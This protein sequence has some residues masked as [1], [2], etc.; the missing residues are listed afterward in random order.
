MFK[1][2]VKIF[3]VIILLNLLL[4]SASFAYANKINT[5]IEYEIKFKNS[6]S[7]ALL[8]L[9]GKNIKHRFNF[10]NS[11]FNNIYTFT[12]DYN[13]GY[14]Q[15]VLNST[16]VYLSPINSVKLEAISAN[17]PGF[18]SNY[19]D[20]DKTWGLAKAGFLEA[21]DKTTGLNSNIVAVIDTGIDE[22]HEDLQTIN[23]VPGFDFLK[24]QNILVGANSDDN[25]HGT[26]VAG[27]L[28]ATANNG[29]GV[30]GTNWHVSIMP[31]KALDTTGKGD[32]VSIA[33]A[34]VWATD[35]GAQFIN[36]SVGGIGFGHDN[37]LAD[38]VTYAFAR[39]VLIVAAAGND[40]AVTGGNIDE[41]PVFPI[42]DDNNLN[43]IIGVTA[44][45]QNDLKPQF[46]NY[47]KNCIDVT[48]PGK[49]ILST[50]SFDPGTKKSSPNSY[51]YAS[52]TSLAVPFVVGQAALIKS[53]YPVA[54]NIQIRDRI[55]NTTD[56]VD[57]LNLS[58]CG[59]YSCKG[60]LGTGRINILRSLES[61]I[62]PEFSE[63]DIVRV[64][65]A[66]GIMY[67]IIGGQKRLIS[68]TVYNLRFSTSLVKTGNLN[69]LSTYPEG[70]YITPVDGTLVKFDTSPTVYIIQNGQK[71]P[72]TYQ[73]FNQRQFNFS[74]VYT[75]S[76]AELN[77][78]S[79]ASFL[80][81]TEGTLLKTQKNKTVY[82]VVG[83]TIHPI[84]YNFY[85]D[86]GL[87]IFPV[88]IFPDKDI[89]SFAKGEAYI[90]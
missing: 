72:I 61:Q 28:G 46:A 6:K 68:S 14:I 83:G 77:S 54:S 33:E 20:V 11:S 12:S 76:F 13:L 41:N 40:V 87:N 43:M 1:N 45:D 37:A 51:A 19:L 86:K 75:L 88:L 63:G 18:T 65:D 32:T 21:W 34:M 38:A 62:L 4:D 2:F 26:L 71:F 55:I 16:Y 59:G 80:S 66:G 73:V 27:V 67:Q 64:T 8:G 70:P 25:G 3:V 57:N 35:H 79:T 78:W 84:N 17:D 31:L 23:F 36:L 69:Q 9:V 10:K 30:T 49:R 89:E 22:T 74:N 90:R 60:M 56:Q 81:P 53:L 15:E 5:T 24:N 44:V 52:G 82:W 48:A 39:N 29:L 42:C 58:Q 47:G 50:I 85:V 7:E